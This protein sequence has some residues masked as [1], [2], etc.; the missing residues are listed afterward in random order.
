MGIRERPHWGDSME[1][2]E[3]QL[4]ET[5]VRRTLSDIQ[6]CP[7]RTIR[8]LIDMALHFAQEGQFK[9]DF[10]SIAQH[11]LEDEHSAYYDLVKDAAM[12][13]DIERVL[14]FGMN[15]GYNGCS[16]GAKI[17]RENEEKH[18]FNIPWSMTLIIDTLR[19]HKMEDCYHDLIRQAN[20]LGVY[21]FLIRTKGCVQNI[22]PFIAAH[23]NCAFILFCEASDVDDSL[24]HAC[25]DLLHL[26]P[27]V[28]LS[29]HA[30]KACAL[31]REK[32]YF[33]ALEIPYDAGNAASILSGDAFET[34]QALHPVFTLFTP[35]SSCP[36][37]VYYRVYESVRQAREKQPYATIPLDL[38]HDFRAIDGI[39]SN[40]ACSACF[41]ESGMLWINP[42]Q[43]LRSAGSIFNRPL[44]DILRETFP[45]I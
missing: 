12:N 37:T 7:E 43:P 5:V 3:Y 31:L 28:R 2:V 4:I 20:D 34:A 9:R 30:D 16:L 29:N 35:M 32:K 14:R 42:D 22:L 44:F 6:D 45:K 24:I 40:E 36:E 11:M 18:H 25:E 19:F 10:F 38:V 33:Y 21:T 8:N 41:D 39:I 23:G 26:M 13:M 15:L 17:I 1:S 27:V